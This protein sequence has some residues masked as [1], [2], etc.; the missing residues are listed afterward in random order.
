MPNS[1][2]DKKRGTLKHG[3]F[4][5]LQVA[6]FLP[7]QSDNYPARYYRRNWYVKNYGVHV[8]TKLTLVIRVVKQDLDKY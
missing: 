5:P 1:L 8:V 2:E 7:H 4:L 6:D 3:A